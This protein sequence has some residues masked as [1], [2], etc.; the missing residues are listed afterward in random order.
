M[1]GKSWKRVSC[2]WRNELSVRGN[3]E[4]YVGIYRQGIEDGLAIMQES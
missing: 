1:L 3:G 4:V 2:Q